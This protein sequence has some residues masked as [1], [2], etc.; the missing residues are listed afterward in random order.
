MR[1]DGPLIA[2]LKPRPP[3]PWSPVRP[4]PLT[5]PHV[6]KP[7]HPQNRTATTGNPMP[8]A[9]SSITYSVP[10]RPADLPPT[11]PWPFAHSFIRPPVHSFIPSPAG[12]ST[13]VDAIVLDIDQLSAWILD[14]DLISRLSSSFCANRP[15]FCS[16]HHLQ[17]SLLSH[18]SV[19]FLDDLR[20]AL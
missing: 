9:Q 16:P 14:S 2:L 3:C 7:R 17:P 18:F 6:V 12:R 20:P 13:P 11:W 1:W 8:P 4:V 15:L 19:R 5:L 10:T